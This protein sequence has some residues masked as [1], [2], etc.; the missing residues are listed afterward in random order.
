MP[1]LAG[2]L[3]AGGR[4]SRFGANKLSAALVAD[5]PIGLLSA[6]HLAEALDEFC[7]VAPHDNTQTAKLFADYPVRVCTESSKGIGHSIAHGVRQFPQADGWLIALADMPSIR[8]ETIKSVINAL[9]RRQDI[10]RPRYRGSA[11]HPVGFGAD[12]YAEL[13]ALTGDEGA[14]GVIRNNS[15]ACR[16]IDVDDAGILLDIDRPEDIERKI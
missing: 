5:T 1:K 7:V 9:H 12:Y 3:L 16:Y 8:V 4:S 15:A 6:Q 14:A 13:I 10:I 11:G 2:I